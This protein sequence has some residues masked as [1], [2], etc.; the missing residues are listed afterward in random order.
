MLS[1]IRTSIIGIDPLFQALYMKNMFTAA[2][3]LSY[4]FLIIF[5]EI[6]HADCT[7]P[8]LD[9]IFIILIKLS[10]FLVY[11]IIYDRNLL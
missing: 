3:Q 10:C 9:F 11:E 5:F 8:N 7:A 4:L 1:T 6:D 2:I